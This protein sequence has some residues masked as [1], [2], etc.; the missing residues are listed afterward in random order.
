MC[1]DAQHLLTDKASN[2]TF[3]LKDVV[4]CVDPNDHELVKLAA[5]LLQHDI[6]MVT[7]IKPMLSAVIS[8]KTSI[9]IGSIERSSLLK[10]VD[11]S[12]K[13][14]LNS[15]RNKWESYILQS[16]TN[17]VVIAGSDRR[18]TAYGVF[19]LSRQLG[20]S[21]WYWWADVPVKK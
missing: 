7:G 13:V 1:C 9:I 19:E 21:P 3:P 11:K 4:I 10:A 18:G 17:S 2:T 20:V 12:G 5:T 14:N 16:T 15:Q 8:K 6:E